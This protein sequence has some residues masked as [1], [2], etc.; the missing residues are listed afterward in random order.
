MSVWRDTQEASEALRESR[1]TRKARI[2]TTYQTV[3]KLK[4]EEVVVNFTINRVSNETLGFDVL[5]KS[6][7][8]ASKEWL[9][10]Y[11]RAISS[12]V[13]VSDSN[14]S[15]SVAATELSLSQQLCITH[16]RKYVTKRSNSILEQH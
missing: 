14:I 13:L 3:F 16:V 6:D 7:T 11:A 2:I 5:F 10:P 1:P 12:E 15:Y 4:S 8:R 9:E